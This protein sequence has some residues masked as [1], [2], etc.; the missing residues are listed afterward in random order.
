MTRRVLRLVGVSVLLLGLAGALGLSA[1]EGGDQSP[2]KENEIYRLLQDKVSSQ[3]VAD[4]VRARGIAFEVTPQFEENL[5]TLKAKSV[6]FQAV[7]A[8]ARLE[9]RANAA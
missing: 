6:L 5:R 8:P 3:E 9:I 4:M 1:Q 7:K 2:L